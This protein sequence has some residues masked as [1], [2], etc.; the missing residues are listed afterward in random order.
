MVLGVLSGDFAFC[1]SSNTV[2]KAA[3]L[4]TAMNP[5]ATWIAVAMKEPRSQDW[6]DGEQ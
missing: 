2:P 3:G 5:G 6:V 1:A 4:L